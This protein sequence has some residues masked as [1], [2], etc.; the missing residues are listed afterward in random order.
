M[1][2]MTPQDFDPMLLTAMQRLL[3][4][5]QLCR[6]KSIV[7]AREP[8]AIYVC[9]SRCV[10]LLPCCSTPSSLDRAFHRL[11]RGEAVLPESQVDI[12][13]AKLAE[14][15]QASLCAR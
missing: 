12:L 13:P 15:L 10:G 2:G 8:D 5:V 3:S 9:M 11:I 6:K 14:T 4:A 7:T 1:A